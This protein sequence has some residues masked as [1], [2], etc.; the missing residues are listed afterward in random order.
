[1]SSDEAAVPALSVRGLRVRYGAVV[2]VD[3]VDFEVPQLGAVALLGANGA[4]KTSTLDAISGLVAFDGQIELAGRALASLRPERIARLGVAHVPEGRRLF[5]NLTVHENLQ[6]SRTGRGGRTSTYEPDMVYELFPALGPLRRRHAWS[7]SGGEQQM[8]AIG[9]ALC[10]APS[11]L[12]LDEPTL[13][14]A[15]VV[16][17]LLYEA[18]RRLRGEVAMVLVEQAT[19]LALA[20]CDHAYVV[21]GGHIAIDATAAELAQRGDLLSTYL[22]GA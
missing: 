3:G 5:P 10:A 15:P 8:V 19:D 7:L 11:V 2:A 14:L 4:G 18:L 16:V 1:M 9:R 21:H 17:D 6:V 22:D 13:G 12:L 20:I